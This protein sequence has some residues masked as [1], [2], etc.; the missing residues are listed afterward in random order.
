MGVALEFVLTVDEGQERAWVER[1][2]CAE[3]RRAVREARGL[4]GRLVSE[5]LESQG[6]EVFLK[7]WRL[8]IGLL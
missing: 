5:K 3:L 2:M 4:K 7:S 6:L 1:E 8:L